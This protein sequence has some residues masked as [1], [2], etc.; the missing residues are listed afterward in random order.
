MDDMF[1]IGITIRNDMTLSLDATNLYHADVIV[2]SPVA[3]RLLI[4]SP[5]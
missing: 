5:G 2:A 1:T 4:G 3:L